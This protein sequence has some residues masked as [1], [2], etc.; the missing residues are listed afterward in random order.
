LLTS[1]ERQ[2]VRVQAAYRLHSPWFSPVKFPPTEIQKQQS[3]KC[4]LTSHPS[5]LVTQNVLAIMS[6]KAMG[7]IYT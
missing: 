5:K 1:L 6:F 2:I 3:K 7:L 4:S